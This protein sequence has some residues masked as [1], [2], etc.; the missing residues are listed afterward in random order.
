MSLES[1]IEKLNMVRANLNGSKAYEHLTVLFDDGVFTEIDAFVKSSDGY[2]EAVA[3]HGYIEGMGVYAFAQNTDIADGAMSKAQAAKIKKIY[4][5]ALKTG[6]PVIA[7]YDS[8]GGR[9]T[10]GTELLAAYGD[11]LKYS[12][13]LSGVVPQISVV[14][15]K[16]FGTQALI[17]A[18]ADIVIISE[19][20]SFS[21][22]T[23]GADSSAKTAA[24]KGIAHILSS[25]EKEAIEKARELVTVLPSNNLSSAC[26]AYDSV[27]AEK[28]TDINMTASQAAFAVCDAGSAV[29]L[30]ADFG[31]NAKTIIAAI[32]GTTTGIVALDG[33]ILDCKSCSKAA[34]F[35][36]FCDAFSIPILSFV[37]AEKFECIKSAAKLTSAYAE[38]TT[39]KITVITGSAYG[40]V[41][42]AAAGTGASADITFAWVKASVSA[43]TPEAEAVIMLGDNLGGKLKNSKDPKSDRTA[44][45]SQF[46]ED[47]LSAMRAAENGYISEIINAEET[48]QKLIAVIDMLC[49]KRVSTLPKKHN[50]LYI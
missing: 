48:R 17:A 13:N 41:Y 42:V 26:V 43:L 9:L 4:D 28:N 33:K 40:S 36:R 47:N 24:E 1:K 25:D 20:A 45:I 12:N 37:D 35:I 2:A 31:K 5:L 38:A 10:E 22:D 39:A 3:A 50:N 11:I 16:C 21:L 15:G 29:E 19:Q 8:I 46:K 32:N 49:N 7:V 6:E 44:V 34:R 30:Q 27:E 18:C 23:S 14:L